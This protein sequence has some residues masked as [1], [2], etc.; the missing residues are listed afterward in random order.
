M[1]YFK[2][3]PVITYNGNPVRNILARVNFK[4]N[5]KKYLNVL[6]NYSL[7]ESD[8][9]ADIV[10]F[11]YYDDAYKDW[12]IFLTNSIT[13]PYFDYPLEDYN[14]DQ[15]IISKYGSIEAAINTIKF[16]RNDWSS[17]DSEKTVDSFSY[18]TAGQ[19][20]YWEPSIFDMT[21]NLPSFY[22]RK[23]EDLTVTTNKI[24]SIAISNVS[25]SNTYVGEKVTIANSSYS[26]T[27]VVDFSNSSSVLIKHIV[28]DPTVID[29]TFTM[30]SNSSS[31]TANVSSGTVLKDVIPSDE[32]IYWTAVSIY[33]YESELNTEKKNIYLVDKRQAQVLEENLKKVLR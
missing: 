4:Q 28:N 13:D 11:N 12:L 1:A 6:L 26:V 25:S 22:V 21:T 32:V 3:F 24:A 10:S 33:D 7:T 15:Y 30:T 31:I 29:Y 27:G 9:R 5:L 23:R 2:Y 19:K 16:Y 17:D 18:L 8:R 20:K 14:F